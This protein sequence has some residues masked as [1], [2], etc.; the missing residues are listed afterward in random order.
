MRGICDEIWGLLET[1]DE[2]QAKT[3]NSSQLLGIIDRSCSLQ[4]HDWWHRIHLHIK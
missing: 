2:V 3:K 1:W 4:K